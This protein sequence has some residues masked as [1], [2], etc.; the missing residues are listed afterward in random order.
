NVAHDKLEG[1]KP[2]GFEAGP[3][4]DP[5]DDNVALD[6]DDDLPWPDPALVKKWWESRRGSFSKDTRYLLGQPITAESLRQSLKTAY[7]RQRAAAALELALLKP[8][9]PL[10]EVRAAGYR[11]QQLLA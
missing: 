3:N 4:E 11:Q 9:R 2:D 10:F 8:G 5:E 1:P 6:P 7:Q